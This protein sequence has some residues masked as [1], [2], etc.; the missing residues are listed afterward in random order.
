MKLPF[1]RGQ[2]IPGLTV[3]NITHEGMGVA[4][5]ERAVLFIEKGVPGDVVDVRVLRTRKK[6]GEAV[7]ERWI[8]SSPLRA[9]PACR[10]FG[11][12]GGCKMQHIRYEEQLKLKDKLVKDA[13]ERIGKLDFP[14]WEPILGSQHIYGYRNR[15]DYAA[16]NQRWL[17][18]EEIRTD[19]IIQ[20]PALG[21]HVPG[22]FDKILDISEC[23]LQESLSNRIRNFIR[24]FAL[25]ND[26]SF[27]HPISQEGQLRNVIV[28]STSTG[29]WM[30][31]VV[32][33]EDVEEKRTALLTALRDAF[34]EINS[35]LYVINAKRNDTLFD[36]TIRL[37]H[38][39]EYIEEAMEGLRF[40]I[41]AKSFYQTNSLQAYELYKKV[42]EFAGLTGQE[43][44]Y[45]LYTGTGTIAQFVAR[46][47]RFVAGIDYVEDA[48][49]DAEN[50]ARANKITNVSFQ[51]GDLKDTLTDSFVERYGKPD[52]VITDPPRA[53]MHPDVV[54]KILA[55]KPD[56][57]VY[58]SCNPTTQAR[59]IQ[60][61][62]GDYHIVRALPVDMFPH[63]MH[64]ESV[65]LL[66][67]THPN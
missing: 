67:R 34:P 6:H 23:H 25:S 15:L 35:L 7:I 58:V 43:N 52:V 54:E 27:F 65:V 36:Q 60:L 16:S 8:T 14:E 10:H 9:E 22:R 57:I 39:K 32:F 21:F 62:G 44:V 47:A 17:T 31:I 48:I 13:F 33:K 49:R 55:L 28:R 51:A 53:G 40:K 4:R 12:C 50:N 2:L 64:V 42:R 20:E 59:D 37:F 56:R 41:S 24:D 30:T 29:E 61:M 19:E 45:D 63:T 1:E 46:H 5:F 38:G 18:A 11:V 3:E 26:I 66:K